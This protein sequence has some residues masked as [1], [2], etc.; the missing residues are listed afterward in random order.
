MNNESILS[1]EEKDSLLE[2]IDKRPINSTGTYGGT[3]G[4][5][6]N[7]ASPSHNLLSSVPRIEQAVELFCEKFGA[8]VSRLIRHHAEIDQEAVRGT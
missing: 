6:Y 5:P 7:F 4:T 8:N 3:D 1:T 2:E